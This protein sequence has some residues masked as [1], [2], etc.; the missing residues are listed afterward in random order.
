MQKRILLLLCSMLTV[1]FVMA[2]RSSMIYVLTSPKGQANWVNI[3]LMNAQKGETVNRVYTAPAEI[4][5]SAEYQGAASQRPSVD[6]YRFPTAT[7]VAAAAFVANSKQLFFV[8]LRVGELRWA[9]VSN[10]AAPVFSS[11]SSPL[12]SKL[13]MDDAANHI[14]RMTVGADKHIYALT[15]DGNH[16]FRITTGAQP[17][18]TDL[19]NLVDAENN[20]ALTVHSQC[21][22]WGGD[23][24]AGTDGDLYLFSQRFNVYRIDVSTRVATHLGTIKGLP[25]NYTING[26]A[27][28]QDGNILVGCSYGNQSMYYV[29]IEKLT[30]TVAFKGLM[31]QNASDLASGN[32]AKRP[33][34]NNGEYLNGSFTIAHQKIS[35]YPNPVTDHRFQLSF[36]EV[37]AGVHT[38]QVLELS[39]KVLFNRVVNISGPG[40]F[41]TV[42]LSPTLARGLY[43]VK[44]VNSESKTVYTNKVMV[45]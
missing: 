12:L 44:V 20:G 15:N 35:M 8:P 33:A 11:I 41:E 39:G 10:P 22:G 31:L 14:T 26:V 5:T 42:E 4:V 24:V 43:M 38:I 18:I 34:R 30:A 40:Q 23:M 17:Q 6:G 29:D 16:L 1:N 7:T 32:L 37:S 25:E 21:S 19:G 28:D 45:Q 3:E 13:N 36:E 2:Q 27:A 9:D